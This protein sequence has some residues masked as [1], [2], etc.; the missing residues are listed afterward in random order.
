MRYTYSQPFE[1]YTHNLFEII[2]QIQQEGLKPG[3][4]G[5]SISN[6]GD[7]VYASGHVTTRENVPEIGQSVHAVFDYYGMDPE[8][9]ETWF[10]WE[11][12]PGIY[13]V[14]DGSEA[15]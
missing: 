10:N 14:S 6:W 1:L 3:D 9:E 12:G 15:E 11:D 7:T 13:Y 2:A 4:D 5:C 8:D